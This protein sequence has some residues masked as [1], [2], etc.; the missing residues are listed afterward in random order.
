MRSGFQYCTAIR[1]IME[2]WRVAIPSKWGQVSNWNCITKF[3]RKDGSQSLLNEVRFPIWVSAQGLHLK[4]VAIPSKWGQVSNL[5]C[6]K[7]GCKAP[8]SQS[9]LNEVRFPIEY[10]LP[11]PIY[12]GPSQSL[13]N[14]VRFPIRCKNLHH[15]K[16]DRSQSLLNEVRFPIVK[17]CSRMKAGCVAIPSK[18]GQVSNT[19]WF[20]VFRNLYMSQSLLN[21]V[22]F[23]MFKVMVKQEIVS[24]NPF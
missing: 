3:I 24:R 6:C 21:E 23:P 9:L 2:D 20:Q 12:L 8:W 16:S 10:R 18:W 19:P 11:G 4:K 13:L 15:V 22:R 1:Y 5:V 17:S 7:D 14:E